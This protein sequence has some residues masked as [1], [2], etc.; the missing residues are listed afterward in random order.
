MGSPHGTGRPDLNNAEEDAQ[1]RKA[2]LDDAK[3]VEPTKEDTNGH[4]GFDCKEDHRL[5][6]QGHT[7]PDQEELRKHV[8]STHERRTSAITVEQGLIE[9]S[10]L[11]RN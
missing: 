2:D 5:P 10:W 9:A 6:L 7:R 3:E 1:G 8:D 11:T 4:S